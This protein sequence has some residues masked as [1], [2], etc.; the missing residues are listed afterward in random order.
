[1][2]PTGTDDLHRIILSYH[3]KWDGHI[4][5]P[6]RSN[7]LSRPALGPWQRPLGRAMEALGSTRPRAALAIGQC[8]PSSTVFGPTQA[9]GTDAGRKGRGDR[10]MGDAVALRRSLCHWHKEVARRL[11]YMRAVCPSIL[12]SSAALGLLP[13]AKCTHRGG[14]ARP[15]SP[16]SR[17]TQLACWGSCG[18][19]HSFPF[20]VA[21]LPLLPTGIYHS[22]VSAAR[23]VSPFPSFFEGAPK[24]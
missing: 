14:V 7:P 20:V 5:S 2:S 11:Q 4:H 1:M 17:S 16:T 21:L 13:L 18:S 19:M 15:P 10:G 23:E 9:T 6:L 22:S 3:E 12:F 8:G 24:C